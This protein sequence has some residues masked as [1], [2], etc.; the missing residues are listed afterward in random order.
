VVIQVVI[1][2][3]SVDVLSVFKVKVSRIRHSP[4]DRGRSSSKKFYIFCGTI[5][6]Q[7]HTT[8]F[9]KFQ[10]CKLKKFKHFLPEG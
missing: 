9:L 7:W 5:I 1:I 3:N 4:E 2:C 10:S 8:T 6:K